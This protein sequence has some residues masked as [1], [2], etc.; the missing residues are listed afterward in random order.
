MA[1]AEAMRR[2]LVDN[3]RRKLS[4]KHGGG[5]HRCDVDAVDAEA[6]KLPEH[7]GEIDLAA[8]DAALDRL[9]KVDPQKAK[10]VELR[11]F[12]G[13]TGNQAAV[14]LG[15]SPSNADRQWVYTRAWL[16]RELVVGA[17]G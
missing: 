9:A 1:A 3:A 11:Y 6:A 13:L 10:L 12:A 7:E 2:I 14:V 15:I 4:P 8:L 17:Q 5:W 16:R